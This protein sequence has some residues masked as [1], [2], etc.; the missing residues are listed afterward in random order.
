M[1][2]RR[3]IQRIHFGG[4]SLG[5]R[6]DAPSSIIRPDILLGMSGTIVPN[7]GEVVP[8]FNRDTTATVEDFEGVLHTAKIDEL[9]FPG[10][11]RVENLCSNTATY[12][13]E[14]ITVESGR[15][16]IFSFSGAGSVA[17]SGATSG[18]L[19]GGGDARV[20]TT[21]LTS[22]TSLTITVSGEIL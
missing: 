9:R 19:N 15:D 16:Y 7:T 21:L 14:V 6:G 12:S 4:H 5:P 13:S 8:T 20:D 22:G 2:I 10:M 18:S 3:P 1:S 17:F 11:R